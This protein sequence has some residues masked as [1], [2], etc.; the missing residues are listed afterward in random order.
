[1]PL[2]PYIPRI[3]SLSMIFDSNYRRNL[4]HDLLVVYTVCNSR[5]RR[6]R[7]RRNRSNK[8]DN[9]AVAKVPMAWEHCFEAVQTQLV[10]VFG[11]SP[12][13]GMFRIQGW[14]GMRI[15]G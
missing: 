15:A 13:S 2:L 12:Q 7:R 4:L 6:R 11:Q 3:I 14:I 1:M 5:R 8:N 10:E 9:N